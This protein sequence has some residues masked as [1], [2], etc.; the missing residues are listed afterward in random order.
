MVRV[1]YKTISFKR[2]VVSVLLI[3]NKNL[4][5][6][7]Y[8]LSLAA[9]GLRSEMKQWGFRP[10][11]KLIDELTISPEELFVL[12]ARWCDAVDS[13]CGIVSGALNSRYRFAT[14]PPGSRYF[15]P[16]IETAV[17]VLKSCWTD[18]PRFF[19]GQ[20]DLWELDEEDEKFLRGGNADAKT[21]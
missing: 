16:D 15:E 3:G 19:D 8:L 20:I 12:H 13:H 10:P 6:A 9:K 7:G 18:D 11:M 4:S 14:V 5:E 21:D 17:P 2:E 1:E